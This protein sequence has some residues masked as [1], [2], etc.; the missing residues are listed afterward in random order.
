MAHFIVILFKECFDD[1]AAHTVFLKLESG[2]YLQYIFANAIFPFIF[3]GM[4]AVS[5]IAVGSLA[6]C[7]RSKQRVQPADIV[8]MVTER[9]TKDAAMNRMQVEWT[10]LQQIL[11]ECEVDD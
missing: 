8:I 10:A 11:T 2:R 4:I 3:I 1:T 7:K 9:T 6:L 5:I